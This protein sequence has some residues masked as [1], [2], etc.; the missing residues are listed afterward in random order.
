MGQCLKKIASCAVVIGLL[1]SS[2]TQAATL[3][4]PE[5]ACQVALPN[6]PLYWRMEALERAKKAVARRD[7]RVMPAYYA[8]LADAEAALQTQPRSVTQKR[9]APPGGDTHD[10]WSLAPYWWSDPKKKNGMPYI[11]RDGETN[12]E[13]NGDG[14]DRRR[15]W[16]MSHDVRTLA[17]AAYFSGD[18]R[19]G[20]HAAKILET[21]FVDERTFM[22]PRLR[23]AQSIPGRTDGRAIGIID[24][25]DYMRLV[26]SVLLLVRE[27]HVSKDLESALRQWFKDYVRWLTTDKMALEER[28]KKNNHGTF[29]DAQVTTFALFSYQCSLAARIFEDTKQRISAQIEPDGR[30]PLELSRTRSLHYMV[31]NLEAFLRVARLNEHIGNDLYSHK[32]PRNAGLLTPLM[33]LLPYASKPEDWPHTEIKRS[34]SSTELWRLLR[35]VRLIAANQSIVRAV[36]SAKGSDSRHVV[37]LITFVDQE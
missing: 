5:Q 27:R 2:N 6:G 10:Y 28:A 21:W 13:R 32:S 8:V 22:R 7:P 4:K 15:S 37:N 16:T 12:A 29:Y 26:D 3:S 24:T 1:S 19:Y 9:T 17:L 25:A 36:Q 35:H 30:M 18:A 23:Y 31:F 34:T 11:R 20:Q 14:F 33:Y